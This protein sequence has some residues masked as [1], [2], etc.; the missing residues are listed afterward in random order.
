MQQIYEKNPWSNKKLLHVT[1]NKCL[2]KKCVLVEKVEN[3]FWGNIAQQ[4]TVNF[5][6]VQKQ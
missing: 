5:D 1:Q 2:I 4:V 6:Y 3:F